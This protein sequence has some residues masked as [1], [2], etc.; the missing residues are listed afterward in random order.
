MP[1]TTGPSDSR[2]RSRGSA[3]EVAE[4]DSTFGQI[5]GR[6]LQCDFVSCKDPDVV[7]A[8]LAAGVGHKLVSIVER[9]PVAHVWQHFVYLAMHFNEFFLGHFSSLARNLV[10]EGSTRTN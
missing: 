4:G 10:R 6:H 8:H 7:L 9:D 2:A 3:F 5:I 1:S